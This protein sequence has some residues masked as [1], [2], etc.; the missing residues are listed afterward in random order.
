[1]DN[2]AGTIIQRLRRE[3]GISREMLAQRAGCTSY[4]I[5]RIETGRTSGPSSITMHAIA[6]ELGISLDELMGAP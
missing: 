6:R 4:T 2:T 5:Y 3:R 1:M